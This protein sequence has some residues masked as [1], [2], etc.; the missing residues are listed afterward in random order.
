M[1]MVSLF[2][3][4]FILY[5][6]IIIAL[7]LVV[8]FPR[9][10][11]MMVSGRAQTVEMEYHFSWQE[12][13]N[14]IVEYVQ[15]VWKEKSLGDTRHERVSVGD[16][17]RRFF[18]NSLK[19]ILPAFFLSLLLGILKGLFD[20]KNKHNRKNFLGNGLTWLLQSI[21]D[22]FIVI[23]I[24]WLVIFIFPSLKLFSQ[25]NWYGFITPAVLVSIY[26]MMY[27]ARITSAA[28]SNEDG[29]FYIQVAKAKGF[30]MS[31]VTNR[32]IL[33]NSLKSI[34]PHMTSLMIHTLSSLLV[35]EYL[36]GYE[37]IA[38]RLFTA[39]GFTTSFNTGSFRSYEPGVIIG[40]GLCFLLLT[41]IAQLT[42][43]II[44][45]SLRIP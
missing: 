25:S 2:I 13:K 7:I 45:R 22:F 33:R 12:Y 30:T 38:Y 19:L 24:Q 43:F 34:I 31:K 39:F 9:N 32:H 4:H 40:I 37:G 6:L 10:P 36:I 18:P 28:L 3:K 27:L 20:Y 11:A 15:M 16:E 44:K 8:L 26:P 21:P 29:Q 14:N 41:V 42:G 1:N 23:C 35:V 5:L 17:I